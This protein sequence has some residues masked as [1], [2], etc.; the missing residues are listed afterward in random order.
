MRATP[1][2]S[3]PDIAGHR[4]AGRKDVASVGA[5]KAGFDSGLRPHLTVRAGS[6][7][8]GG[9][10]IETGADSYRLAHAKTRQV[11]G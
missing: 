8:V 4:G 7:G 9:N 5:A 3:S 2:P 11:G 10:I 1:R 6:T